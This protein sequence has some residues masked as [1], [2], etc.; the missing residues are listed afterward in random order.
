MENQNNGTHDEDEDDIEAQIA[1]ELEEL[2]PATDPETGKRKMRFQGVRTDTE[3]RELPL[4]LWFTFNHSNFD[5]DAFYQ[6]SGYPVLLHWI[7]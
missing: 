3:C 5:T 4:L 7:L 2:Q 6:S 1:K